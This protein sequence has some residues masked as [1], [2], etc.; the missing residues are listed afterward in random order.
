ML[1]R[2]HLFTAGAGLALTASGVGLKSFRAAA[3]SIDLPATLPEGRAATPF[4]MRC[5]ARSP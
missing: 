1:T 4:S 2:R 5:Q 3:A